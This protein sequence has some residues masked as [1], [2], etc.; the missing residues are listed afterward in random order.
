MVD[1]LFARDDAA[2]RAAGVIR[3]VSDPTAGTGGMLSV[4]E[5]HLLT[6]NPDARLR[7]YGQESTTSP[8]RSARP[9]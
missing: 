2:L 6:R 4:A 9:T 3:S 8:T 5:E 7:L 1:L